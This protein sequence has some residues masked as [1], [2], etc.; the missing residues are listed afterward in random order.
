MPSPFPRLAVRA[1]ILQETRLL[2]VNAYPPSAG[3]DLWWHLAAGR[4]LFQTLNP[5]MVDDWSY[6][7]HGGDW[8]N[9]EWLSDVVFY[10]W[11][12]LFGLTSLVY[13]KWAV[14]VA[15]FSLLQLALYRETG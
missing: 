12:S 10:S 15:T 4:E 9:H 1:V 6:S 13:W 11:Y 3:S 7:Q 5:W 2:M 14:V 8:L